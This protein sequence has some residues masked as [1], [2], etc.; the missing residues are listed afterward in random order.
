[1]ENSSIINTVEDAVSFLKSIGIEA[2]GTVFGWGL[3]DGEDFRMTFDDNAGLIEH[4]RY[5]RDMVQKLEA[6]GA[7][8]PLAGFLRSN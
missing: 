6:E 5:E 1:M 8:V 3:S 4:A 7:P 2:V